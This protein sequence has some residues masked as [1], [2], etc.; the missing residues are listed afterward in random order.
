[1]TQDASLSSIVFDPKEG[2]AHLKGIYVLNASAFERIYGKQERSDIERLVDI[3]APAM[4]KT[5]VNEN[6]SALREVEAIFS[7]WGAPR[8]DADFLERAPNLKVVFYGAGSIK[9]VVSEAFWDR[10]IVITSAYGANA[11]PV[12][13]YALSQIL[14]SL[15]HGW[16]YVLS[17]KREGKYPPR[18]LVPGGYGSTVGIISLGMIGRRV[19]RLLEPFDVKVVAFDPYVRPEDA[20]QFDVELCA[21]DEVFKRSDVVSLHTPWL[22]ETEG[23]I[24]GEHFESMKAGATFINTARGA[25]V[26][27]K[28]MIEVLRKRED[29]F[30]VLD[31]T[32]PEPPEAGSPL[33]I[34]PNVVLTPHIAGSMDGECRRMGRYMV[35][36]L[37]RYLRGEPLEWAI[38][39]EIAEKLA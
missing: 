11:V 25:V 26:R 5:S 20:E 29:L 2:V 22:K 12:A 37:E 4:E 8:M 3:I 6:L 21:L 19:C 15:K 7:G 38:T 27:E 1:M 14:F 17:A 35:R 31:V 33:Y 13:E 32:R 36:E 10:G 24:R 30:A 34:L 39:K 23:M 16:Y 9:G 28:E 18:H